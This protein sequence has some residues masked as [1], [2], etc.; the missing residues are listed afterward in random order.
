MHFSFVSEFFLALSFCHFPIKNICS[1]QVQRQ[2]FGQ[3][4][5]GKSYARYDVGFPLPD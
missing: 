1:N 4:T 2:I 3:C 5:Y